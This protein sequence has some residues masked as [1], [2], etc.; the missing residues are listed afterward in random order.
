MSLKLLQLESKSK[1]IIYALFITYGKHVKKGKLILL[2]TKLQGK[3]AG[4][5]PKRY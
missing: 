2:D 4:G 1:N 5:R 3:G